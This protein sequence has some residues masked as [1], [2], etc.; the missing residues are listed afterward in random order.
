MNLKRQVSS[1]VLIVAGFALASC[2][3]LKTAGG[4]SV[5]AVKNSA[6]VAMS[7]MSDLPLVRMLPGQGPKVVQVHEKELRD[8]P[9]GQ[10]LA[11]AHRQ[12]RSGFWIFGGPVDFEEPKLPET[13]AELDGSLLPPRGP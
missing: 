13:G 8:Q 10:E 5:A 12:Q 7:K 9:T 2:A 4:E 6:S 3:T 1:A 11:Q